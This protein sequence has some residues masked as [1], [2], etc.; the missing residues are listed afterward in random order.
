MTA[1]LAADD[2]ASAQPAAKRR[3]RLRSPGMIGPLVIIGLYLLAAVIGPALVP[4][5]PITTPLTDRLKPPGAVT[6]TGGTA[7]LGT[8]ALGRDLFG[9][10]IHGARTSVIIGVSVVLISLGVGVLIGAVAGFRGGWVDAVLARCIDILQAFPGLV[11]AIVIAGIFARSLLLV[12]IALSVTNWISFAR[13]TRGVV[14][15]LRERY[16]VDA[17]R[18]M[19]VPGPLL[20]IR[21][22]LPFTAGPLVAMATLEFALVVL[23]EAGLSFLGIG[24]PSSIVSWGQTVAAGRAYLATAWWISAWPG[25][26]LSVLVVSVG[27]LGDQLTARF[28]RARSR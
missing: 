11:L 24:L 14:L 1:T 21:H 23:A 16:W 13:V 20:L 25:L 28:G 15:T 27:I 2:V 12:I 3:V 9:Q 19:G 22:V 7:L 4:Y 6:S 8:D 17:A 5:D 10:I 18:L 26:A